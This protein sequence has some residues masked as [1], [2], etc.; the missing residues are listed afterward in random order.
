M[1][2]EIKVPPLGESVTEASIAKLYKKPGD[3]VKMDELL[4]ELETD[5]VTLEINSPADGV[6]ENFLIAEGDT[7]EV[8]QLLGSVKAGAAGKT[9]PSSAPAAAQAAPAAKA[10]AAPEAPAGLAPSVRKLVT[11][12][13]L[14][15]ADIK[16][17]GKDG[18]L[19]KG[20]V[21]DALSSAPANRGPREERVK[22]TRL[23][24]RIAERLKDAQNTAAILTTLT[25]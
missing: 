11:E 23:R 24:M 13:N 1:S 6:I 20:D 21:L 3:A 19:I 25:K 22:M 5:K 16:G 15:P 7:V 10:P 8:G 17:S 9:A 12:N 14:N 18:R 4:I 2:I